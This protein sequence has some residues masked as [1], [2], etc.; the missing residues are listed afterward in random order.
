MGFLK[1]NRQGELCKFRKDRTWIHIP[2]TLY[3]HHSI[4]TKRLF[5]ITYLHYTDILLLAV[6]ESSLF[7]AHIYMNLNTVLV[8][9]HPFP[10]WESKP[11]FMTHH[12][13]TYYT[14]ILKGASISERLNRHPD[15]N[16]HQAI[17]SLYG[18]SYH[19]YS[20]DKYLLPCMVLGLLLSNIQ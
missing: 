20:R 5:I 16:N 15:I 8:V 3:W 12:Q 13:G 17:S 14:M 6:K 4:N 19:W 18:T 1:S 9:L 2:W 7:Q 11:C 10:Q